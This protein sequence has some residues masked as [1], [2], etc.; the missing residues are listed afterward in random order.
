VFATPETPRSTP[1][2]QNS[3]LTQPEVLTL[4]IPRSHSCRALGYAKSCNWEQSLER[5]RVCAGSANSAMLSSVSMT[6]ML[7]SRLLR[8]L[9]EHGSPTPPGRRQA[10]RRD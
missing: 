6:L 5:L 10:G 1:L 7:P 4:G 8:F 3:L 2:D 9:T